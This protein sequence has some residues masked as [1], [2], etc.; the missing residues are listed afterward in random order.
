MKNQSPENPYTRNYDSKERFASY[1]HQIDEIIRLKPSSIVEVGIGTKFVSSY[2]GRLGYQVTTVDVIKQ[3]SPNIVASVLKLPFDD[4]C[5]DVCLCCEVLEHLPF[6]NF[7]SAITELYRVCNSNLVL[8]LP[9]SSGYFS[10]ALNFPVLSQNLFIS[11]PSIIK[12]KAIFDGSHYWE[13]GKK[14]YPLKKIQLAISQCGFIIKKTYRVF[15]KPYHRIFVL[16]K[17]ELN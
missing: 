3:L 13:I 8:S 4:G 1:W 11:L 17:I 2:I 15:E 7:Q 6:D 16:R 9:D 12:R 5:F 14:D 10:V